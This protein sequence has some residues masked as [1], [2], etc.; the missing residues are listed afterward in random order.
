[1]DVS[2]TYR[3]K[4]GED[5]KVTDIAHILCLALE[6]G[7]ERALGYFFLGKAR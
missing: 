4:A 6:N 5:E 1:M 2:D 3:L 7:D